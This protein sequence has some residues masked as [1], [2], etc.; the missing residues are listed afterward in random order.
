M[1]FSRREFLATSAAIGLTPRLFA[2]PEISGFPGMITRMAEPEN[3]EFPFASLNS[4]ITP[5]EHFFVRSH[6]AVPKIEVKS[7][8]LTVEGAVGNK[9]ELGY[10]DLLKMESKSLTATLECAGN[11]RVYLTPAVPGLQW[12]QGAVGNAE[13]SGVP[14]AA[15]LEK[16]RVKDSAVELVLEGTDKGQVNSDPK[17]PGPIHFARSI[18]IKKATDGSVILAHQMNNATLPASHGYPVRAVVGG[19]YGVASVKWLSR[20]IVI[21]KPYKGFWQTLDYSYWER[22]DGLPHL[23]PATTMEV[24]SSIARPTLNEV[25]PAGKVYRIFGAAWAGESSIAKVE[26]STDG[27]TSWTAAKIVDNPT[28]PLTWCLWESTWQVP[29]KAGA[30]RLMA[31]ATDRDKRTQP[32]ERDPDR[33]SY[34]ISHIVPVDVLVR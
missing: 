12:G 10:D 17:S 13:W 14:L 4:F 8:K 6:F 31:R 16:A 33:R 27:G 32:T 3:L 5:N 9:L 21:E 28:K 11:G 26:V 24:K 23:L 29:A 25:I 30:Y 34:M 18:P 7:W 1:T 19:W 20:I 22:K 15:I 2:Q